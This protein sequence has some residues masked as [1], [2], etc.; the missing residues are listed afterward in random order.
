MHVVKKAQ[1][2][3]T[4]DQALGSAVF[5]NNV[6]TSSTLVFGNACR[7]SATPPATCGD[8]IEVPDSEA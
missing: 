4:S 7:S 5:C 3:A 1:P 2:W 6:F 8:D